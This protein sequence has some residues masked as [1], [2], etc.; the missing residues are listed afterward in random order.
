LAINKKCVQ[1]IPPKT[2]DPI[3]PATN[4]RIYKKV[5][6]FYSFRQFI[7]MFFN[8]IG[9]P[10]FHMGDKGRYGQFDFLL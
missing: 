6:E 2:R 7:L 9:S 10:I 4:R 5:M 3:S 1:L 8:Y